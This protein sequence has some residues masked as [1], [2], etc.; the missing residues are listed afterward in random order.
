M[1]ENGR[2]L[3]GPVFTQQDTRT[4]S[5]WGKKR[6]KN[7]DYH[8]HCFPTKASLL[9]ERRDGDPV[10]ERQAADVKK[11]FRSGAK[12]TEKREN[13]VAKMGKDKGKKPIWRKQENLQK[14]KM[15]TKI[16]RRAK[17]DYHLKDC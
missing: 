1:E 14:R 5:C 12:N 17:M 2:G 15:Q 11:G 8:D 4:M 9:L 7:G 3:P 6:K 16:L 13:G 10:L